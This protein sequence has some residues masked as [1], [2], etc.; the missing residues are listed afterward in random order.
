MDSPFRRPYDIHLINP[1]IPAD[2]LAS[3]TAYPDQFTRLSPNEDLRDYSYPL[4][5]DP[6]NH[7]LFT[8]DSTVNH[9][10]HADGSVRTLARFDGEILQM[11]EDPEC[12]GYRL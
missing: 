12:R 10:N 7:T 2:T 3:Y 4:A 8:S 6:G 5:I 9:L 1:E 11:E